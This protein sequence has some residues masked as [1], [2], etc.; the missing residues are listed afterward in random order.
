[1]LNCKTWK[2]VHFALKEYKWL[3]DIYKQTFKIAMWNLSKNVLA[4]IFPILTLQYFESRKLFY[5][6]IRFHT[7]LFVR[8]LKN[9]DF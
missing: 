4:N 7:S 3:S 5:G 6:W 9:F 1:M 2:I 8:Y